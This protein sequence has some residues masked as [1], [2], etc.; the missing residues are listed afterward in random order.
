ME[1]RKNHRGKKIRTFILFLLLACVIWVLTKSSNEDTATIS[2][3]L[4]YVDL[5]ENTVLTGNYPESVSF[6][7]TASGFDF[8]IHKLKRPIVEIEVENYYNDETSEALIENSELIRLITKELNEDIAVRN[9]SVSELR[10]Q[11]DELISKQL[12]VIAIH[13][14]K[15]R[16]GFRQVGE[17]EVIPDSVEV[18][19]TA[20]K[21]EQITELNTHELVLSEVGSDLSESL[22][23]DTT[24]LAIHSVNPGSVTVKVD[25]EEFTQKQLNIDIELINAPDDS[26]VKL[27]PETMQISFDVPVKLFNEISEDEFRL[28]CDYSKRNEEEVFM[29]PELLTKPADVYNIE[30]GNQKI[31]YLLFKQ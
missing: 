22:R 30:F 16:D 12:P 21:L 24:A 1:K 7:L 19:G 13:D 20:A 9:L 10:L 29:L 2:G 18:L 11:L 15:Y 28:V 5:P 3:L 26:T 23:I 25:V 8:L 4:H 31:D 27:I 6:D 17:I 14:L